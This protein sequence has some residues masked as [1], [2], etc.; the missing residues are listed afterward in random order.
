MVRD[1]TACWEG[2]KFPSWD[3]PSL[4]PDSAIGIVIVTEAGAVPKKCCGDRMGDDKVR[5][6]FFG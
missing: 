5:S 2:H 6:S 3:D 1:A 4:A